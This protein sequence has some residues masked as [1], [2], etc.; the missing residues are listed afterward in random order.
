LPE[1]VAIVRHLDQ[2]LLELD[3]LTAE[4]ERAID[5]LLE[6]RSAVIFAAA[7]GKIDVRRLAN[8]QA[9]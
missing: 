1:Q 6:R 9:A 8:A 3:S 5:L 4:A 7:T 2:R